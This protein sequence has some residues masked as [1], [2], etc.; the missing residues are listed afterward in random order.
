[1]KIKQA[2]DIC[3]ENFPDGLVIFSLKT[4]CSHILNDSASL[5]WN[6][7]KKPKTLK[8]LVEFISRKY[9]IGFSQALKDA[10][11]F[12]SLLEKRKLFVQIKGN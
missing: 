11:K 5:I 3:V 10:K 7:C 4:Y 1:M 12:I 6:F 2:K 9:E 8:Q